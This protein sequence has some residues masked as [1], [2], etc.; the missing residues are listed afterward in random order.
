MLLDGDSTVPSNFPLAR[1]V[2]FIGKN[3]TSLSGLERRSGDVFETTLVQGTGTQAM[4]DLERTA[5]DQIATA[6]SALHPL[7]S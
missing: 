2:G 4:Q 7:R 3:V 1:P 6:R 5:S